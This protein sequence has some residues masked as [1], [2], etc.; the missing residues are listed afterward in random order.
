MK[1]RHKG[2]SN[3]DSKSKLL[4]IKG[5]ANTYITYTHEEKKKVIWHKLFFDNR[6]A[7]TGNSNGGG[8]EID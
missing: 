5:N 2:K 6:S 7:K 8:E 4:D 3:K 1:N